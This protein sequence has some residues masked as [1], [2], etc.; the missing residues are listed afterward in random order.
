MGLPWMVLRA[1]WEGIQRKVDIMAGRVE[2]LAAHCH[3]GRG[4]D[5]ARI[6]EAQFPRIP[7]AGNWVAENYGCR[8][9]GKE[10]QVKRGTYP[11]TA[12]LFAVMVTVVGW[13][14]PETLSPIQSPAYLSAAV[15]YTPALFMPSFP[16]FPRSPYTGS[17]VSG[18]NPSRQDTETWRCPSALMMV[19][20]SDPEA[21]ISP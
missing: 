4:R 15:L 21:K 8:K 13:A 16:Q 11:L 10:R 2:I 3:G 14:R 5:T 12:L 19:Y 1:R 7:F 17:P 9:L 18:K 20:L 6:P